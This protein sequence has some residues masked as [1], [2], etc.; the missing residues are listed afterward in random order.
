M[1]PINP[2]PESSLESAGTSIPPPEAGDRADLHVNENK[3]IPLDAAEADRRARSDRRQKPTSPWG[4]FPPAG[5]RMR[6]RRVEEHRQSYFADRFSPVVLTGVLMLIIATFVDAGLTVY[7]LHGGGSEVNP[8]MDRLLNHSVEAFVIGK[9]L[10]TVVGLPVLLIFRNY[11]LFG[12][13][14][15]VGYLIP[16]T[17]ALYAVLIGYQVILIDQRI[18]W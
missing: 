9:Y 4:A 11:Y 14:L 5:R 7:V 15:R 10:L 17:V 2:R 18:G 3:P 12:T 1:H 8:L 16:V 6:N 13:Q